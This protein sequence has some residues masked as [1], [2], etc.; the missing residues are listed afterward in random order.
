MGKVGQNLK[1]GPAAARSP[2]RATWRTMPGTCLCGAFSPLHW[3]HAVPHHRPWLS[4]G[5]R[6]ERA[7]A[8]TRWN[9]TAH[10]DPVSNNATQDS[11]PPLR[12]ITAV[13][14]VCGRR[15]VQERSA[16]LAFSRKKLIH[17]EAGRP[18]RLLRAQCARGDV[19]L[20]RGGFPDVP[21][22]YFIWSSS[23]PST[24][25]VSLGLTK[26][27]DESKKSTF[28]KGFVNF[29]R[30][31]VFWAHHFQKA[32]TLG[33]VGRLHGRARGC[34]LLQG[35]CGTSRYSSRS[36][37]YSALRAAPPRPL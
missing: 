13:C 18:D 31:V 23:R 3:A 33:G 16:A 5:A 7:A 24:N 25:S 14:Y 4:Q 35:A 20:P 34:E 32:A 26:S 36:P 11:E 37:V 15:F 2:R 17:L 6:E 30:T 8:P 27:I 19:T 10:E 9:C 22:V 21:S 29:G 28:P 12:C 1:V